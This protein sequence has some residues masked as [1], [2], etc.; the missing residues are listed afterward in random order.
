MRYG[1][2]TYK[3]D[4]TPIFNSDTDH[5]LFVIDERVIAGSSVGNGLS[6]SYAEFTGFKIIATMYSPY[7]VGDI[8]GWAVPSCRVV[9][10]SGVPTVQIFVDNSTAGLPVCNALLIVN[11]TGEQL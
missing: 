11:Y 8:D 2:A 5:T 1:L 4:G 9:Y 7:Q 6:I 3:P 10:V